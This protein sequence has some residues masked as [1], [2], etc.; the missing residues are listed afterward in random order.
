[1]TPG[2]LLLALLARPCAAKDTGPV[3]GAAVSSREW[4]V[5]R[6]KDEKEEEFI[7]NVRYKAADTAFSSDWALYRHKADAWKA[8]GRV[9]VARILSSGDTVEA[10]GDEG[11]FSKKT[12]KGT[13]TAKERVEFTRTPPAGEPDHGTA[14]RM[15]WQGEDKATLIGSVHFWGPRLETWSD[16]ADYEHPTGELTLTGGRPVLYKLGPLAAA[17]PTEAEKKDDW[18]GA[19]KGDVIKAYD[20]P[21][22]VSADGKTSG[23]INFPRSASEASK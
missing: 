2:L 20:K 11:A 5:R 16:R 18:V 12:G 7:G 9:K 19:V 14:E 23:W 1:M 4:K 10:K 15:E 17:A 21:R 13:L 8:R 22:R 3:A 6:G